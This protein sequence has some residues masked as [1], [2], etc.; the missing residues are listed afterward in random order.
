MLYSL[1]KVRKSH[2]QNKTQ[3][4]FKSTYFSCT[5]SAKGDSDGE[6]LGRTFV[7]LEKAS[8]AKVKSFV[9]WTRN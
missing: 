9:I 7:S 3:K 8:A 6:E 2:K 4:G 1:Q 5:N